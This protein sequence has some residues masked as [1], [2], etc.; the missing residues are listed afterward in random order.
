MYQR[1]LIPVDGIRVVHVVDLMAL[2][3]RWAA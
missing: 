3:P 1:I 2:Q